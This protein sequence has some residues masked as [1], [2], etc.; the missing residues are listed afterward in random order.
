[1]KSN[2]LALGVTTKIDRL[3]ETMSL[4][5]GHKMKVANAL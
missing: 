4:P 3:G 2:E 5:W 1:M